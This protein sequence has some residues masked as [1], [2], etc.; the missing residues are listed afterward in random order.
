MYKCPLESCPTWENTAT[1][2]LTKADINCYADNPL[3]HYVEASLVNKKLM[4]GELRQD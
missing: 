2:Q 4:A 1:L 3:V